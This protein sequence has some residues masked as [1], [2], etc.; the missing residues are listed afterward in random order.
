MIFDAVQQ[1]KDNLVFRHFGKRRFR[2]LLSQCSLN[3][4]HLPV[5]PSGS[6]LTLSLHQTDLICL[7]SYLVILPHEL[8][9]LCSEFDKELLIARQTCFCLLF[10]LCKH[11]LLLLF[12]SFLLLLWRRRRQLFLNLHLLIFFNGRLYFHY[13]F[14]WLFYFS[15]FFRFFLR[16]E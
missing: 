16:S 11:N 12:H 3:T 7:L 5:K 13:F 4:L 2:H 10:L 1:S 14:L 9:V 8:L 15:N 6:L